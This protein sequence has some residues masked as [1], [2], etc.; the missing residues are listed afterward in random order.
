M[1]GNGF[2]VFETLHEMREIDYFF[3]CIKLHL[4]ISSFPQV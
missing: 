2:R 3:S 4:C 1:G